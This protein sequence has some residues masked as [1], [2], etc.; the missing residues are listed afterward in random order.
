MVW[1]C[2][3]D[4]FLIKQNQISK[5][6]EKDGGLGEQ[7]ESALIESDRRI[8]EINCKGYSPIWDFK[9]LCVFVRNVNLC[10]YELIVV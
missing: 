7:R 8:F 9:G 6:L 10:N 2:E 4:D 3:L 1:E 5:T